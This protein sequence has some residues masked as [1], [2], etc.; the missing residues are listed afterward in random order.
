MA[1]LEKIIQAPRT[2]RVPKML[3]AYFARQ[4]S[5]MLRNGV[6]LLRGLETLS[7]QL[8]YPHF[9]VVVEAVAQEVSDGE[10]F[11]RALSHYP[12]VFSDI[13]INAVQVGEE[14]GGL[15]QSL[16][17]LADWLEREERLE[18]KLVAAFT[19]PFTVLVVSSLLTLLLFTTVLPTFARIFAEMNVPLPW[20][21][22]VVMQITALVC[23]PIFWLVLLL[24]V[25]LGYRAW[26]Q[27]WRS[28]RQA[29]A[30]YHA[31]HR[32]PA[33]GATL[34]H[35]GLA[36][37][38]AASH[39]MLHSGVTLLKT[40]RMSGQASANPLLDHDSRR[41]AKCLESGE[42]LADALMLEPRLYSITMLQMV[43]AGE[44]SALLAEMFLRVGQYHELEMEST[45]D[46]LSS[47]LEPILLLGV[48]LMVGSIVL[49]IY[50]PMYSTL[51]NLAS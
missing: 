27:A 26:V 44:E 43:K 35:G 19:Y 1:K 30:L 7:V 33:I 47:T 6:T 11:S 51:M 13:F 32:L 21:T 5:V 4:L 16:N 14:T 41:V 38:C 18:R 49:S 46:Q 50:L 2:A 40:A 25:T 8:E 20:L 29:R 15:D 37:Y 36:R 45:I 24:A 3:V 39:A 22:W 12:R 10:K 31:F 23:T 34:R 28:P 42:K 17:M 9:G 48:A